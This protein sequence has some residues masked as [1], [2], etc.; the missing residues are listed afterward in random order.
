MRTFITD[1]NAHPHDQGLQINY[2]RICAILNAKGEFNPDKEDFFHAVNYLYSRYFAH[3]DSFFV[4][5]AV[6]QNDDLRQAANRDIGFISPAVDA[7][8]RAP[9]PQSD[10]PQP[11]S[12]TT[13]TSTEVERRININRVTYF[14]DYQYIQYL[15]TGYILK[16]LLDDTVNTSLKAIASPVKFLNRDAWN[17]TEVHKEGIRRLETII[18]QL[19]TIQLKSNRC[20]FEEIDR[21][22]YNQLNPQKFFGSYSVTTLLDLVNI[23]F[24]GA[25]TFELGNPNPTALI[26]YA[27]WGLLL[28]YLNNL[29][30]YVNR[31]QLYFGTFLKHI[32]DESNR[33]ELG[34]FVALPAFIFLLILALGIT[35]IVTEESGYGLAVNILLI[36]A[37]FFSTS[38]KLFYNRGISIADF[39]EINREDIRAAEK[40]LDNNAREEDLLLGRQTQ[41]TGLQI[42][43]EFGTVLP[44]ENNRETPSTAHNLENPPQ[45]NSHF[46]LYSNEAPHWKLYRRKN[47]S[48]VPI[49]MNEVTNLENFLKEK[50]V[51]DQGRFL[52]NEITLQG[53]IRSHETALRRRYQKEQENYI[54][55]CSHLLG[56]IF[57]I[58]REFL[59]T[60]KSA[61]QEIQ[62]K[63]V[64]LI[65]K[66]EPTINFEQKKYLPKMGVT[67]TNGSAN[68]QD[69][70]P[71]REQTQTRTSLTFFGSEVPPDQN[72]EPQPEEIRLKQ[73]T[74][75]NKDALTSL[76]GFSSEEIQSLT[77]LNYF[78]NH[79]IDLTQQADQI[80]QD[81]KNGNPND[82]LDETDKDILKK[83]TDATNEINALFNKLNQEAPS[84]I[85]LKNLKT[86][87]EQFLEYL[88]I[89]KKI[90][91]IK[92]NE[93]FKN[94]KKIALINLVHKEKNKFFKT[95]GGTNNLL[96][97]LKEGIEE[98]IKIKRKIEE[99]IASLNFQN[100]SSS[101]QA[102]DEAISNLSN[103][104]SRF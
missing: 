74:Q 70:E 77:R 5:T 45:S 101:I 61:A 32:M 28:L 53:I 69:D 100:T 30:S 88:Q 76:L 44:E 63:L 84:E 68:S 34:F 3:Q 75:E 104:Q 4:P 81:G 9:S 27:C 103:V 54:G 73:F 96:N 94:N 67:P 40:I 6:E 24:V 65:A 48:F 62:D 102:F 15:L 72:T 52:E 59:D 50:K 51:N 78:N 16:C 43:I 64:E 41:E 23:G 80:A 83:I 25:T 49:E 91:N 10:A 33:Q 22:Y 29:N 97:Q 82:T 87:H 46:L 19:K 18:S 66:I 57:I 90:N 42:S 38:A 31:N 14:V 17:V 2:G 12:S 13:T 37:A 7:L 1:Q 79:I 95:I 98:R 55:E 35:G 20:V 99:R 58:E 92:Q 86:V 60:V 85:L 56:T 47:N 36:V 71:H 89:S 21:I 26:S 11:C 8:I 39:K 93:S